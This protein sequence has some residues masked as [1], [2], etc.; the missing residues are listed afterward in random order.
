[1][2][3]PLWTCPNSWRSPAC[4]WRRWRHGP[5][6]PACWDTSTASLRSRRSIGRRSGASMPMLPTRHPVRRRPVLVLTIPSGRDRRRPCPSFWLRWRNCPGGST[7][8]GP[9]WRG[10]RIGSSTSTPP[11]VRCWEYRRARLRTAMA[12]TISGRPCG[13]TESRR[14]REW[15]GRSACW[16][17]MTR[18][19]CSPMPWSLR[20]CRSWLGPWP[21]QPWIRPRWTPW[22]QPWLRLPGMLGWPVSIQ[23]SY[24]AWS[25][26]GSGSSSNMPASRILKP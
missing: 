9:D 20:K 3:R 17:A 12:R 11:G 16:P 4:W 19:A 7:R 5:L 15:R 18:P 23:T 25:P 22:R 13:S 26:R 8:L 1:M 14:R 24:T 10:I 6:I 21:R 2:G